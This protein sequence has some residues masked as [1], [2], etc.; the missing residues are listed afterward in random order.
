M[1]DPYGEL[2]KRTPEL[3]QQVK[4]GRLSLEVALTIAGIPSPDKESAST[5]EGIFDI[6]TVLYRLSN[7]V[8]RRR[9][10]A[11]WKELEK[12]NAIDADDGK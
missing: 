3:L 11:V 9:I 12:L 7:R 8:T 6:A 1:S 2:E 10:T 4:S 5:N